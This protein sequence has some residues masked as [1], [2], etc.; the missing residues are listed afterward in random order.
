MMEA[1]ED[2]ILIEIDTRVIKMLIETIAELS[3]QACAGS[4]HSGVSKFPVPTHQ[5]EN[6]GFSGQRGGDNA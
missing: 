3:L 2:P 4:A 6:I 5:P 1:V